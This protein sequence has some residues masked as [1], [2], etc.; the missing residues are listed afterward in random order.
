MSWTFVPSVIGIML[1]MVAVVNVVEG[2]SS[3]GTV[4]LVLGLALMAVWVWMARRE[5]RAR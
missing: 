5:S 2:N 3:R 1:L 4:L